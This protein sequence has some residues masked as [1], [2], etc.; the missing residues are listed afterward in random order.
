[1]TKKEQRIN[2]R[3]IKIREFIES[4][5]FDDVT[6]IENY[7]ANFANCYGSLAEIREA[8][9]GKVY[10][11]YHQI[12]RGN[13][14]QRRG[15]RLIIKESDVKYIWKNRYIVLKKG[16]VFDIATG[17][18]RV[19][20]DFLKAKYLWEN[21][22][23]NHDIWESYNVPYDFDE[24]GMNSADYEAYQKKLFHINQYQEEMSLII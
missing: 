2:E 15:S 4:D 9:F 12:M 16:G 8:E 13:Y 10:K 7:D 19:K 6:V 23:K 14:W 5:A 17:F 3:N 21:K 20:K 18:F 11:K 1:M 24:F 22:I